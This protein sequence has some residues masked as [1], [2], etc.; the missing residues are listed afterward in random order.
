ME[1]ADSRQ[2]LAHRVIYRMTPARP[3]AA[4]LTQKIADITSFEFFDTDLLERA[5]R[6][7]S[8]TGQ[9]SYE[10]L[11]FLGDRVLGII[12]SETLFDRFPDADQGEL[13]IRFHALTHEG[14]L[15]HIADKTGLAT[16]ISSATQDIGNRASVKSDVI[17]SLIA[18]L[19]REGGIDAA[20]QFILRYWEFPD[21]LPDTALENPK[22][23]LQEWSARHKYGVPRYKLV[24][25]TG[26]DHKPCFT[27][28][29]EIDGF[30]ALQ[31]EGSTIKSAERKAA[32]SLLADVLKI[33]P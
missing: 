20:R 5:L 8:V 6:H 28:S 30:S 1:M 22:S 23:A 4:S 3:T 2:I 16:L 18:A 25:R 29:V 27:V 24:S 12:I 17:E 19:H 21:A 32:A 14:Y 9:P 11:E 31:A 13:T 33:K 26:S 7:K 15:A 10:R